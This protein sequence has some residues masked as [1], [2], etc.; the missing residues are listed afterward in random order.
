VPAGTLPFRFDSLDDDGNPVDLGPLQ[1]R[2]TGGFASQV[3]TWVPVS[4]VSAS[5]ADSNAALITPIGEISTRAVRRI[6]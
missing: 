5:G 4:S 3:S 2:V 6:G 1:V